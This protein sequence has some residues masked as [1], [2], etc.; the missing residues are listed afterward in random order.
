M[1]ETL[2]ARARAWAL[3]DPDAWPFP[4]MAKPRFGSAGLGVG[5]VRDAEELALVARRGHDLGEIVVQRVAPGVVYTTFHHAATGANVITT[6]FSDWATNCPE[7]KVTAVEVRKTN[8]FSGWQERNREEDVSMRRIA[9]P[10]TE[11]AE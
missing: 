8:H 5:L 7:Y 10:V 11:A 1:D 9:R 3:A 4:L 2:T 6:D